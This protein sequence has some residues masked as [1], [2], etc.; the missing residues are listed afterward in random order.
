MPRQS[1]N[2]PVERTCEVCGAKFMATAW[3]VSRG[4]GRTCSRKCGGVIR[5]GQ[6]LTIEERFWRY[7]NKD[8]PIPSSCPERGPCWVWTGARN[9]HTQWQY[10]VLGKTSCTDSASLAHRVSW[11]LHV[12]PIPEGKLVCHRCDNP[13]CVNPAHLFIGGYIENAED[14]MS[15]GRHPF[16]GDGHQHGEKNKH[17]VLTDDIV[18]EI[19]RRRDAGQKRRQVADELFINWTTLSYVW[20]NRSWKHVV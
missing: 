4:S 15:K 6:R 9:G 16:C 3:D 5:R 13:P 1:T 19:R 18:R 2:P 10:G 7:V 11:E 12:G 17:S 20:Y 14:M 8:G